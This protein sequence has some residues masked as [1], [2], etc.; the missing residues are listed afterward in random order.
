M[1]LSKKLV[2]RSNE[3]LESIHLWAKKRVET[4]QV[5]RGLAD[6]LMGHDKNVHVAKVSGSSFSIAGFV[7]MATGFGLAPVTLGTSTI[8]SAVGGAMCAAGGATAAGSSLV[9]SKIFKTKLAKVQEIIETDRQ[10]QEPV[11]KLLNELHREVSEL[12]RGIALDCL[13]YHKNLAVLIKNLVDVGKCAKA[14]GRAAVTAT[15]E[16]VEAVL[17]S[18][19]IAGNAARFG[20]FAI[21]AVFLPVDIYTLVTSAIKLNSHGKEEPQA[22]KKLRDLA[23]KLEREMIEM[24]KAVRDFKGTP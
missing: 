24:L 18:T 15:G 11:E 13:S 8:L 5:L 21:S 23:D 16:G 20:G 9:G 3:L 4:V 17:R 2:R 12:S 1:P 19:G 22:V 6:E 7:L 10:A 14:G